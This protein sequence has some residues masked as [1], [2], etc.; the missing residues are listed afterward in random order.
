MLKV[1]SPNVA[2]Y[3]SF[4]DGLLEAD[5]GIVRYQTFIVTRSVKARQGYPLRQLLAAGRSDRVAPPVASGVLSR[6]P[7]QAQR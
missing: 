1:I 4:M 7:R 2:A 6:G 5:P 3:Q